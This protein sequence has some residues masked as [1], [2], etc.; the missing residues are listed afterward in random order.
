MISESRGYGQRLPKGVG[1]AFTSQ[2]YL[3]LILNGG[4]A[5]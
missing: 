3:R 5:F 1:D 4:L 2:S